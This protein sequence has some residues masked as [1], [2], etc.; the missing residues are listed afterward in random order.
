M[1]YVIYIVKRMN[2]LIVP[3][4]FRFI[5]VSRLTQKMNLVV[6]WSQFLADS[7]GGC[8]WLLDMCLEKRLKYEAAAIILFTCTLC[9]LLYLQLD[10]IN[11][12]AII[13]PSQLASVSNSNR[14]SS[15][16]GTLTFLNQTLLSDLVDKVADS[17]IQI[18]IVSESQNPKITFGGSPMVKDY[19]QGL[20][21]GFLYDNKLNFVTNYHVVEDAVIVS[22]RFPSG[23]SY[24]ARVIGS[25]PISDLAVVQ[26]DPS[27]MFRE[28]IS[29]LP[30][31][32]SSTV[33]VGQPVI[34]I[35]SP[36]GFANT[37]TTGIVS[38][39]DRINLDVTSQRYW[40]GDFIQT[41]ADINPGNSGGPLLN[42]DGEVIGANDWGAVDLETGVAL[43]GLN[44]AISSN[45]VQKVVPHLISEG[46]YSH[47]WIGA[48]LSDVTPSFAEM[49]GLEDARGIVVLEVLPDSPAE[50]AGIVQDSIIFGADGNQITQ[51]ADLIKH[52]QTKVPD[53]NIILDVM[54]TDGI[55]R[56]VNLTL[57]NAPQ[58]PVA[59]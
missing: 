10:G 19:L 57:G 54:G 38:Q 23:N 5:S 33:E 24:S 49:V 44:F 45:T 40:V 29:P 53:D 55:R 17:V 52:L 34:A 13:E 51:I 32:N 37:V 16:T 21:S 42:L 30:I 8:V 56:D 25:D 27:A 36:A 14:T 41:D 28:K 15:L 1:W 26:V 48:R 43:P 6:Y 20:G 47:P 22:A 31:A 2:P 9:V 46:L 12:K 7:R 4:H 50:M 3:Y 58:T 11:A 39:T 18:N 35:G 59:D